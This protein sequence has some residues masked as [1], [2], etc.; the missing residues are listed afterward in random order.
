VQEDVD[1]LLFYYSG[2]GFY[3]KNKKEQHIIIDM[4][5]PG[6]SGDSLDHKTIA[7]HLAAKKAKLTLALTDAC[8]AFRTAPTRVP[9]ERQLVY[10]AVGQST[11]EQLLYN[12]KGFIYI[13]SAAIGTVAM[14]NNLHTEPGGRGGSCFTQAFYELASATYKSPV[15]WSSFYAQLHTRTDENYQQ[16]KKDTKQNNQTPEILYD[17]VI[18]N[19][20]HLKYEYRL[21]PR[22]YDKW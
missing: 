2:H 4:K 14:C 5:K 1:T 13:N 20:E 3:D 17:N 15:A 18:G 9:S 22:P 12:N 6:D 19:I 21:V 16:L 10:G 8:A 11:F 7:A